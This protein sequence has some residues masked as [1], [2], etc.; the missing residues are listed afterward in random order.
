MLTNQIQVFDS[1]QF[2]AIRTIA[3][4]GS[5][6]FCLADV[7]KAVGLTN[8]SSVKQRLDP[9]DVQL[10]DLHALN[11]VEGTGNGLT[12]FVTESGFFDILLQSSSPE[13]KPFRKWV[14]SEVLP[15]IRKD[16]G[17]IMTSKEDSPEEIMARA[18]LLAQTTIERQRQRVQQL[19]AESASKDS[20]IAEMKPKAIF[21]DALAASD[22]SILVGE[23]AK[24][25]RQNGIEMGQNR[26]F[27]YL[28]ENGYLC[29]KGECYNQPSQKSLEMGL[30]EIKK[31]VVMK[32][33]GDSIIT[34][35]SKV[36]AKGQ[37]YFVN[38]FLAA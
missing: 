36:T 34:T 1:P 26:L 30:F 19:E 7:C 17:Y 23:L 29:T 8:P 16:G 33:N 21:A 25:L 37:S 14:T 3:R 11:S 4:E 31:T 15:S 20:A 2:G 6:L 28:R 10:I 12:N 22:K 18:I 27:R 5:P 13:V 9:E 32:P 24:I 38:R 35:T